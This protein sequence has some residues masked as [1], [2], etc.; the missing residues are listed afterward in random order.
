MAFNTLNYAWFFG[1]VFVVSW[2]LVRLRLM[3]LLFLLAASYFFYG[4]FAWYYLPLILASSSIDY[5]LGNRIAACTDPARRKQWLVGTVIVNLGLLGFFK[6]WDFGLDTVA[7]A[8]QSFGWAPSLPY[9]RLV[10]PI[11]ISFFTFESMSYVIDVYRGTTK[12]CDS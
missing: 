8:A 2:L 6:Y 5:W 3:R 10:L 4:N 7:T 11:G 1:C 9:L 12:P